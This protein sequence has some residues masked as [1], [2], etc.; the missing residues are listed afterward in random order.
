MAVVPA[1][2]SPH[3]RSRVSPRYNASDDGPRSTPHPRHS[4]QRPAGPIGAYDPDRVVGGAIACA[5]TV[6]AVDLALTQRLS[7]F[8]DLWF[9]LIGLSAAMVVRRRGLFAVGVLPPLLMGG[10]VAVLALLVPSSLTTSHLAF[11]STWLTGLAHH[12][13]S[14]VVTHGVVLVIV[15]LR[16]SP[17]RSH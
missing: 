11:V 13:A 16:A 2:R 12:G 5:V 3:G 4:S 6:M 14:L 15:G 17:Q 10:V 7:L 1:H 9:V 8:F